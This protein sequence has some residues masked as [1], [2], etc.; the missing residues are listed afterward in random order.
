MEE[1]VVRSHGF[2]R[3]V[4]DVLMCPSLGGVC[5]V[6]VETEQEKSGGFQARL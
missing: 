6:V 2:K 4:R 5:F 3:R 1:E